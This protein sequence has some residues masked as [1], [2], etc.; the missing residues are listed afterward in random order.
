ER[1]HL[2]IDQRIGQRAR[3]LGD[4]REFFGPVEALAGLDGNLATLDAQLHAVAVEFY[5][6]APAFATRGRVDRGAKLRSDE[7]RNGI[8]PLGLHPLGRSLAVA[9]RIGPCF[10]RLTTVGVPYRIGLAVAPAVPSHHERLWRPALA[11]RDLFD[12]SPG[13]N[14]AVLIED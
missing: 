12:R 14:R 8:D 7:G 2:A 10:R 4:R 13:S 6:V 3:F 9:L 5:L 1:D 11:L